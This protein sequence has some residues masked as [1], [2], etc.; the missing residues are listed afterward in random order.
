MYAN[1]H[2]WQLVLLDDKGLRT[3]ALRNWFII[4]QNMG[5]VVDGGRSQQGAA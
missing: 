2:L 5:N 1:P 4:Q 3:R